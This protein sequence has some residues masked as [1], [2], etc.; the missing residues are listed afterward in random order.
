MKSLTISQRIIFLSS[1]L[2]FIA[3]LIGYFSFEGGQKMRLTYEEILNQSLAKQQLSQEIF[4]E[5]RE[6]RIH[7]LL[8]VTV[9]ATEEK[10]KN[11]L[12]YMEKAK[13]KIFTMMKNYEKIPFRAE[14]EDF[15]VEVKNKWSNYSGILKQIEEY[16][17]NKVDDRD[18]LF[19]IVHVDCP[20]AAIELKNSFEELMSFHEKRIQLQKDQVTRESS[21]GLMITLYLAL[22]SIVF[23]CFFSFFTIKSVNTALM[24]IVTK[25]IEVTSKLNTT[26]EELTSSS[27]QLSTSAQEQA[28]STEEISS[29]LEEITG[30]VGATIKET[31]QTVKLSQEITKL[32]DSGTKSMEVLEK[33]MDEISEAN[34]KVERL[35]SLIEEIGNKTEIID[36]IVFQTRLLSFNASVEAE[37]AGEYGRG[38]AVVAQ[39]VGNLAQMSGKSATEIGEIVKRSVKEAQEVVALNKNKVGSGVESSKLTSEKLRSIATHVKEIHEAVVEVQK[40]SEEQNTGIKQ[41]NTSI[42]LIGQST[43][44]NASASE[45]LYLGSQVLVDQG[46]ALE[47]SVEELQVIVYGKTKKSD[48]KIPQNSLNNVVNL[49]KPLKKE[50]KNKT[51][52]KEAVGQNF[53]GEE[54]DFWNQL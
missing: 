10:I 23:G 30:M 33:S 44:E 18:L 52:R 5:F 22:A 54:D 16:H 47:K 41:I 36:E 46:K 50:L 40:A 7:A 31:N 53:Q 38:F 12:D 17:V 51:P 19:K 34:L 6:A 9:G 39:E 26:S 45:N 20:K 37:R 28:S 11:S 48:V 49:P 8:S 1:I 32:V 2:T 13:S 27:Q 29:N 25:V 15:W 42:Q 21:S 24:G 35:V 4:L 14:E 3:G 43:Q